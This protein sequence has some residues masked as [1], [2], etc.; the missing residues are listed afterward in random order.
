MYILVQYTQITYS[1]QWQG[2][3]HWSLFTNTLTVSVVL[4]RNCDHRMHSFYT[5]LFV[6]LRVFIIAGR[7][8]C[9]VCIHS[10]RNSV[11]VEAGIIRHGLKKYFI[12]SYTD[13]P[14]STVQDSTDKPLSPVQYSTDLHSWD[15]IPT[16]CSCTC[17]E[18]RGSTPQ[19]ACINTTPC[20]LPWF[21]FTA[22]ARL[23]VIKKT[24]WFEITDFYCFFVVVVSM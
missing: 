23:T 18:R 12:Y 10:V 6:I 5:R 2:Q 22:L 4:A 13:K 24:L 11:V 7:V 19:L 17:A 15:R 1:H 9:K 3:S 8:S 20:R 14:V 21:L 16:L